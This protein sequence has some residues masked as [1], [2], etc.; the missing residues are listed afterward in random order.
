MTVICDYLDMTVPREHMPIGDLQRF[1]EAAPFKWVGQAPDLPDRVGFLDGGSFHFTV[2]AKWCRLSASGRVLAYFRAHHLF[3]DYLCL[4]VDCPY[5]ITRLD[6]AQDTEEYG[7][8]VLPPL[9]SAHRSGYA[10]GRKAVPVRKTFG[11]NFAGHETGSV[12][13]GS[14]GKHQVSMVVYD[15]QQQLYEEFGEIVGPR[16][17]RELRFKREVGCTLRDAADPAALFHHYA[18]PDFVPKPDQ[19]PPWVSGADPWRL[20]PSPQRLPYERAARLVDQSVDLGQL[21][22]IASE[23]GSEGITAVLR[24]V[25]TRLER[26]AAARESPIAF[27]AEQAL[28]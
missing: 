25:R 4:L 21:G 15:K 13:F 8:D 26:E 18:S 14:K 23:I 2:T 28:A 19:V 5:N 10:F 12:F 6:A 27:S 16:V 3:R 17:R 22:T 1:L 11:E 7:P 20:A 9:W 24:L